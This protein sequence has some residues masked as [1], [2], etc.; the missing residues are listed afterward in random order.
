MSLGAFWHD[1]VE[2]D[3]GPKV[4]RYLSVALLFATICLSTF[5]ILSMTPTISSATYVRHTRSS[6]LAQG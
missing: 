2:I 3:V 4:L 5:S 6:S 1:R